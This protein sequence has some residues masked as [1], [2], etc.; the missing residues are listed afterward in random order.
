M[1]ETG[2]VSVLGVNPECCWVHRWALV[3]PLATPL[4]V[5][6]LNKCIQRRC[7]RAARL[8][9]VFS[10]RGPL[11]TYIPPSRN[12]R[13]TP[14]HTKGVAHRGASSSPWWFLL[15]LRTERYVIMAYYRENTR[16]G[17]AKGLSSE[18]CFNGITTGYFSLVIFVGERRR[19]ASDERKIVK[20]DFRRSGGGLV[21]VNLWKVRSTRRVSEIFNTRVNVC[22]KWENK[23]KP[24]EQRV[25]LDRPNSSIW[26][27]YIC[28]K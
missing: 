10:M 16:F 18:T 13:E 2:P 17:V 11:P 24:N 21:M 9:W 26:R 3:A 5:Y 4:S 27:L 12:P 20:F 23:S 1:C 6:T 28:E 14:A 25:T 22:E 8:V 19:R 15:L 7:R